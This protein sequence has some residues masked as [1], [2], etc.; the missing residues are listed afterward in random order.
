VTTLIPFR[1]T[2]EAWDTLVEHHPQGHVLQLAAWGALK[3]AFGWQAELVALA[4]VPGGPPVAGAQ[5]LYRHLPL[6]LGTLAYIPRGPLAPA[7]WWEN[8]T[9]MQPLWN[10]LHAAARQR[11]ARWLKVEAPDEGSPDAPSAD[12]LQVA[13]AAAGMRPGPQNVQPVR[14]IVID[15]SGGPEAV[16]AALKQKT[17]YNIRLSAKKDVIVREANAAD[18]TSFTAMMQVTG[19]RDAFGVHDPAYYRLAFDLF[20]P[21]GRAALFL[22]SYAGQDLAGV[23]AFALGRTAWYFYGASTN[24][25]RNRMP[26]YAAQWAAL[27]W[28]MQRGCAVYDLWGVPD[29]GEETLEAQFADRGD[30]LWGVYRTKRGWGGTLVRRIPAWDFVYSP[31]IYALYQAYL[32]L[33]GR[34][35]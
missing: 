34:G 10:A 30:G 4:E 22:A 1:P 26:T 6:R 13:L 25:E 18:V 29:E 28:A 27:E 21:Q 12:A 17:R 23:M 14:T 2:P 15:L 33:S 20:A 35:E 7:D 19:Q 16:L 9:R 11:G 31:P 5:I 32:R 8:P 24:E 3:S